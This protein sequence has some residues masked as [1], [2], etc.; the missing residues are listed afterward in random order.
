MRQQSK[1]LPA[2]SILLSSQP[3]PLSAPDSD[4]KPLCVNKKPKRNQR[5]CR[6]IVEGDGQ[7]SQAAIS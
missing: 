6:P 4:L 1:I 7:K 5:I 3:P 2:F